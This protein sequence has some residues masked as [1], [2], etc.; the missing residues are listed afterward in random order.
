MSLSVM[1]CYHREES[2]GFWLLWQRLERLTEC[3]CPYADA[4]RDEGVIG[5]NDHTQDIQTPS[6]QDMR[7]SSERAGDT[8]IVGIES[9]V[10]PLTERIAEL[11]RDKTGWLS[12]T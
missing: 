3:F 7:G 4:L 12:G 1:I 5:S 10:M 9:A 8:R 11:G 2:S 6:L